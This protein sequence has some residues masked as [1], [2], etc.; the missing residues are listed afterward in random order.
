MAVIIAEHV[1]KKYGNTVALQDV[2]LELKQGEILG[3]LGTNGSGKTTFIKI[4]ATLLAKDSGKVEIFGYDI[5]KERNEQKIRSLI[6]YVGQDTE[7]SAY[8]RLTVNENLRFFGRLR[9]LSKQEIDAGIEKL[10]EYFDFAS[11]LDKEFM[12]LSGGQKQMVVIM[13]AL[14][15]D[16]PII[17]LDEPTKGLDPIVA[18]KI[19]SFLKEYVTKEQKT[20]LL[21]SHNL[22][23]VDELADRVSLMYR[24]SNPLLG[25]SSDLKKEIGI[26]EFIE[27]RK[28]SLPVSIGE[29]IMGLKTVLTR[30]ETDP[31]WVSFGVTTFFE[32][33]EDIIRVLREEG[34]EV[35]FRH[36]SV[37]LEDVFIN[38]VGILNEKFDL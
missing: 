30:V 19:R 17:Y 31:E 7:R 14:L 6:G 1:S 35:G 37:T 28:E 3:L 25:T 16:P 18:K 11:N 2:S 34:I 9:G 38:S 26:K 23:E 10:C 22:S 12:R 5:D 36:R 15:H 29:K 27:V 20:L 8:A 32:G 21:T 4:L 24:G 13:R 33:I